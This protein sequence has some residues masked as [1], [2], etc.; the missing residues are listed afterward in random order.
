MPAITRVKSARKRYDA[1]GNAKPLLT[2]DTCSRSI[3]V[4]SSYKHMSIKTGPYSSRQLVRCAICPDWQIWEY[5]TST[6]ARLAEIAHNVR[7]A[8]SD[9]E[10]K[11]YVESALSD[12]AEAVREIANEKREAAQN[13]EDGFGHSTSQS[14]ELNE[15]ADNLDS[16]ADEIEAIDIPEYPD[17]TDADCEHCNGG[18]SGEEDCGECLGSGHPDEPTQDQLDGW[19][20]EVESAIGIIDDCPM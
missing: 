15:L 18:V 8:A 13:I 19:K 9:A 10:D 1:E 14:D 5:S 3:E 2:C 12:A 20:S 17:P 6:S 7:L 11:E 4:G 16:W